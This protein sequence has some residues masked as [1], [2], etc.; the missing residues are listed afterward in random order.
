LI[1]VVESESIM[2]SGKPGYRFS[3]VETMGKTRRRSQKTGEDEHI[4][5][6]HVWTIQ[7]DR[8]YQITFSTLDTKYEEYLGK[9][10]AMIKSFKIL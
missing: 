1:E 2:L 4:Q 9:V 8:A 3:Y 10:N 7:D 5:L 6:M